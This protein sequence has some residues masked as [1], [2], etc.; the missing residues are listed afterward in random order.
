M[1]TMSA[2][3][4]AGVDAILPAVKRVAAAHSAEL[5][6]AR[7][8]QVVTAAFQAQEPPAVQGRRPRIYYATQVGR[9]PPTIVVFSSIPGSVHP[10][11]HRYL[12]TQIAT[13][14][15]LK[16]TPLRVSFRARH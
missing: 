11:Y 9:R 4:G 2:K 6:T 1:L 13:A 15:R 8:N 10:S 14:F 3:T 16:G 12:A 7:L 5:Q